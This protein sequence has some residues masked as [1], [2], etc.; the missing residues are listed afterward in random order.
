MTIWRTPFARSRLFTCESRCRDE[1]T[2][3]CL[4]I[5]FRQTQTHTRQVLITQKHTGVWEAGGK[6]EGADVDADVDVA[7]LRLRGS[8][9]SEL[10]LSRAIPHIAVKPRLL[11]NI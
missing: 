6:Y 4:L 2:G 8:L 10:K 3:V 7:Q 9:T 5:S 11:V 1:E